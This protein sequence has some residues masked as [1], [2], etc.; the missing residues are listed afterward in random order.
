MIELSSQVN[1]MQPAYTRS[2]QL[3]G[4]QDNPQIMFEV[5]ALATFVRI[6]MGSL[7]SLKRL[8]CWLTLA[9]MSSSEFFF[10]TLSNADHTAA[11]PQLTSR[12][13]GIIGRKEFVV[14]AVQMH[15]TSFLLSNGYRKAR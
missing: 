8:F 14:A 11:E 1:A 2:L 9:R 13:V 5:S 4:D 3:Q 12:Q 10:L 7:N 15:A 6:R